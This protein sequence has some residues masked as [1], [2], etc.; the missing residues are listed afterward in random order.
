MRAAICLPFLL[1]RLTSYANHMRDVRFF[2]S[3]ARACVH[4]AA[5]DLL[6]HFCV[7]VFSVYTSPAFGARSTALCALCLVCVYKTNHIESHRQGLTKPVAICQIN[8]RDARGAQPAASRNG[9]II[10]V[11]YSQ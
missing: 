1:T 8:A 2:S 4:A 10:C 6:L 5:V 7:C 3:S 9:K 11:H